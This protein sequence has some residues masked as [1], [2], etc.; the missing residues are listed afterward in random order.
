MIERGN[1]EDVIGF[2]DYQR[3]DLQNDHGTVNTYWSRLRHLLK[4]ADDRRFTTANLIRPTYPAY[5]EKLQGRGGDL[6]GPAQFTALCK[7]ARA[8]FLWAIQEHPLLYRG[9]DANWV[10]SIRP[11]RARAEQAQLKTRHLYQVDE[12]IQLVSAKTSTTAERRTQ[13]AAAFLF[14]SAMRIGA[15]TT[16]PIGCVD[17][18]H[19]RVSQLP[20][21]GVMT[22][23][24]KAAVTTLLRVPELLRVVSEWDAFLRA[25]LQVTCLWYAHL[26]HAG[27]LT[28]DQPDAK[29]LRERRHTFGD[30]LRRLCLLAGVE[31]KSA[32]KFRHG[33][34]VFALKRAKTVGQL[35]AISQ[36]LMH[37]TIGITDGIYGNLVQDD[38]HDVIMALG[39]D[40]QVVAQDPAGLNAMVETL[41]RK[42]LAEKEKGQ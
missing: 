33:H 15:F 22:K 10:Q 26:N 23:N 13:A 35:K 42:I 11:P 37:S 3:S 4:W 2:L 24:R 5:L 29:A 6:I 19:F 17:L 36:N 27:E 25:S 40:S 12:V 8:F 30:E 16:L 38:V 31:Y 28:Q 32:H 20:E 41:L 39:D 34:A 9:I 7:T 1:Y 18:A 21:R 14:L